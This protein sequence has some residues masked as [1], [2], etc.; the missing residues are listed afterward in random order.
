MDITHIDEVEDYA[1][2]V[3]RTGTSIRRDLLASESGL[4][5]YSLIISRSKARFSP[6]HRHNFEQ[7]RY[8]LAGAA[9]YSATG[10]LKAGML[11]YFPEGVHYGPQLTAEAGDDPAVLVLQCGGASELGT[12]YL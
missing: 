7:Y 1:A 8:Q 9:N 10:T 5:G 4:E 6:R 12:A 11:G 2:S 3:H